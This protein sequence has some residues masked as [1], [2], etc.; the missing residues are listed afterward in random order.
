[1]TVISRSTHHKAHWPGMDKWFGHNYGEQKQVHR[2]IFEIRNSKK[3]HEENGEL[4]NFGLA[5]KKFE[6][7]PHLYDTT[8]EGKVT[9]YTH[10]TYALA[11]VITEEAKEDNLYAEVGKRY[12]KALGYSMRITKE[13]VAHSVLNRAFNPAFAGADGQSFISAAHPTVGGGTQSNQ[14]AV[15][16]D[17]SEVAL[18]DMLTQL[19]LMRDQRGLPITV[20]A[21][22]LIIPVQNEFE[23][24]RILKSTGQPY[25]DGNNINAIK[26]SGS[27][28]EVVASR[29]LTD[30]DAFFLQT[31]VDNGL[32][33][34][35][36]TKLDYSLKDVDFNTG[37]E[38]FRA[39]ERYSVGFSDWRGMIGSPGA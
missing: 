4:V 37:N 2:A 27:V 17:L 29:F 16:S 13:I 39:R 5:S 38:M 24:M 34:Y 18:E 26:V 33:M 21:K 36:R 35:Q 10:C 12:S 9:R 3:A 1:M 15:A 19:R 30:P 7:E 32:V 11:Y 6:G 23:A 8:A 28:P 25:T 31:D 20:A 22:R 14:L